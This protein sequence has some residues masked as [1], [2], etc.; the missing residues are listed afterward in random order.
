MTTTITA[1]GYIVADNNNTIYG[2]GESVADAWNEM[3]R[4]MR[5]AQ[6]VLLADDDDSTDQLGSWTRESGFQVWPATRALLAQ[7]D[8][9]G[10][11][12]AWREVGGVACTRA[13][14]EG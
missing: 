7:V 10:G 12:L 3:T 4:V 9:Q 5:E 6:V 14:A 13:E 1:A 11:D 2:T 8:D